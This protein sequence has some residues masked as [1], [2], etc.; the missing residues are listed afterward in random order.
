[1]KSRPAVVR[2]ESAKLTVTTTIIDEI[3]LGRM[4]FS[5]IEGLL[6]PT[7]FAAST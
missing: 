2:I 4:Y 3:T 5:R 1:M 7:D 6:A